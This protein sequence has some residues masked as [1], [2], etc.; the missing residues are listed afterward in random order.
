MKKKATIR[1]YF[2]KEKRA[3][4][5]IVEEPDGRVSYERFNNPLKDNPWVPITRQEVLSG[6]PMRK[7]FAMARCIG[8]WC[9]KKQQEREHY[10]YREVAKRVRPD[11]EQEIADKTDE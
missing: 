6:E 4:C 5:R 2:I 7:E 3:V 8:M 10:Y 1:Y 9:S 11:D